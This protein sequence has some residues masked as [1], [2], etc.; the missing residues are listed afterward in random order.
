MII[1]TTTKDPKQ[2]SF[3]LWFHQGAWDLDPRRNSATPPLRRPAHRARP[4]RPA[5]QGVDPVGRLPEVGRP[6]K[7]E[8]VCV[9]RFTEKLLHN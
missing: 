1:S 6:Q 7:K 2:R 5:R 4:P 9:W 8:K 3:H